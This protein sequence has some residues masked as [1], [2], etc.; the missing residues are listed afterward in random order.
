MRAF[1]TIV[2]VLLMSPPALSQ[3]S[4]GQGTDT[5]TIDALRK[6]HAD[7]SEA[8]SKRDRALLERLFAD[9][10]VSV[11]GNGRVVTREKHIED[12]LGNASQFSMSTR[13][14]GIRRLRGKI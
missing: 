1:L 9:G 10:Y 3:A 11:Q 13:S 7:Y 6:L 4:A 8:A 14:Q 2:C 5:A 12:I